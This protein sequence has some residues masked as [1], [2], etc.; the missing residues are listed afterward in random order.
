[1]KYK[2]GF[3]FTVCG[4]DELLK[5]GWKWDPNNHNYEHPDFKYYIIQ[6]YM[7]EDHENETLTVV[8]MFSDEWYNVEENNFHW[9][10]ASFVG[11]GDFTISF[12]CDDGCEEG[13][14]PINGWIICKKCGDDLKLVRGI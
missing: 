12:G 2:K 8:E 7:I 10:V 4:H 9:P 11:T 6:Q 5:R 1:M 14:T 13:S 3:E